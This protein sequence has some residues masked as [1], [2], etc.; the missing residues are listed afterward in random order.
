MLTWVLFAVVLGLFYAMGFASAKRIECARQ[1]D[2]L[3]SLRG[4]GD[5]ETMLMV[6]EKWGEHMQPR[7]KHPLDRLIE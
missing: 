5:P 4:L 7:P 1:L 3:D 2:F 6:L